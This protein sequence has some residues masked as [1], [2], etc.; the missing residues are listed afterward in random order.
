MTCDEIRERA[1]LYMSG[2]LTGAERARFAAHLST[3][4]ACELEIEAQS[5]LDARLAGALQ[6]AVPDTTR[7]EAR[8]R[9]EI[10]RRLG[11]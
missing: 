7:L 11:D 1:P 3:C 6:G 2:E 10:S 4:V 9:R 5:L 8:V